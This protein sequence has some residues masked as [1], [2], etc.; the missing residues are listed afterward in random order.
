[1]QYRKKGEGN[2]D[3]SER[4]TYN[5]RG[6]GRGSYQNYRGGHKGNEKMVYMPKVDKKEDDENFGAD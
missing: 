5:P 3:P 4:S 6:R 1:M 2:Y